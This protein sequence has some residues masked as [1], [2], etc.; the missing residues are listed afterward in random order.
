[1]A[2][3]RKKQMIIETKEQENKPSGAEVI[4]T[5]ADA[6]L[7]NP[8]EGKVLYIQGVKNNWNW[9]SM[10]YA[11]QNFRAYYTMQLFDARVN[12]TKRALAKVME[13]GFVP[14]NYFKSIKTVASFG[15]GPGCDL[16]GFKAFL[17]EAFPFSSRGKLSP[18]MTGYDVELG[19]MNYLLSLGFDFE[20]LEVNEAFL[21]EFSEADVI[22]MSFCTKEILR[23]FSSRGSSKF[24]KLLTEKAKLLLIIDNA[25][26]STDDFPSEKEEFERF[27]LND[28]LGNK[29]VV[30]SK[31]T[32]AE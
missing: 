27:Y 23:E 3:V 25:K 14:R 20:H 11:S 17:G 22:L 19:W 1:M 24:W 28:I 6:Q 9:R 21:N 7:N 32:A 12:L 8:G 29:A 5:L 31:F 26:S 4:A 10:C 30:Y 2:C 16:Y 13:E 18:R 15:C